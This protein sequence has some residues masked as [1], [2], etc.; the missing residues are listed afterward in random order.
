[1][2]LV[3][4]CNSALILRHLLQDYRPTSTVPQSKYR[5]CTEA[6]VLQ[7]D[8]LWLHTRSPEIEI[9][10]PA[11]EASMRVQN[12]VYEEHVKSFHGAHC[13]I[14]NCPDLKPQI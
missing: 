2:F 11:R 14:L 4:G 8:T 3:V 6:N 9:C 10:S 13:L 1:L 12:K 5:K 7:E